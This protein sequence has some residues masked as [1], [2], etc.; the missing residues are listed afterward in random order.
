MNSP[1]AATDR[2]TQAQLD[3][4]VRRLVEALSPRCIYLFG[5]HADGQPRPESD[6]DVMVVLPGPV[7]P[8]PVCYGQGCASLRGT[9]L[10]VELHFAS[11]DGFNR[12]RTITGS[13]EHEIARRGTL[14][15]ANES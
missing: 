11:W 12:R 7:P 9:Y 6:I 5:S 3:D 14:V 10:P 1:N 8:V 2:V 15:Y 4:I 13:L